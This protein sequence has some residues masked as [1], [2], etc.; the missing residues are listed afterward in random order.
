MGS[1]E[2][3]LETS[4]PMDLL[5]PHGKNVLGP[6]R[7][8]LR[9][10]RTL[11]PGFPRGPGGLDLVFLLP[12]RAAGTPSLGA[13]PRC[14]AGPRRLPASAP[15]PRWAGRGLRGGA[16]GA[17]PPSL[18]LRVAACARELRRRPG[19]GNREPGR[20]HAEPARGAAAGGRG[21][22]EAG[23]GPEGRARGRERSRRARGRAE[24]AG[25]LGEGTPTRA[26]RSPVS[27][28]F[29]RPP[30]PLRDPSSR[31]QWLLS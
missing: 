30:R 25:R 26:A 15:T 14:P 16:A 20:R 23:A 24:G 4:R 17:P 5:I 2:G 19:T 3:H 9:V 29:A 6:T 12:R 18:R 28:L 22:G 31:F 8:S 7:P 1:H 27:G 21:G 13:P 10:V 11:P